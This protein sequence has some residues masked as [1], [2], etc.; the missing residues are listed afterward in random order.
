[1]F[2]YLAQKTSTNNVCG[3]EQNASRN[4]CPARLTGY[5][6]ARAGGEM[7]IFGAIN[8]YDG[9]MPNMNKPS[10]QTAVHAGAANKERITGSVERVTFHSEESGFAVLKVKVRGH[11]ELV[12]VVGTLPNI[13]AGEWLEAEGV[14]HIDPKHGQQFKA[15]QMRTTHPDTLEGIEKYLGSGMIKG[16]GPVYAEKLVKAFGREVFEVIDNRSALLERVDGIGPGRRAAIKAAWSEHKVVREIMTFLLSHGVSTARAFRIYKTYGEKAIEQ[17]LADPY[18]LA[19]DIRGIG[20]KTADQIALRMGIAHNSDLRARAG[21]EFVL[22]ELTQ[23]GH[24]AYPREG[25]VEETVK[26][27]DIPAVIVEAAIAYGIEQERLVPDRDPHGESVIYLRALYLAETGFARDMRAMATGAH[28]CPAIDVE[29][30]LAWVQ[31]KVNLELAPSQQEAIRKA[32]RSKVMIITGGPGVGKTTIVNAILNIFRA[33]KLRVTLCAPT[34]RAA[35]RM[36]ETTGMPAKTIHRL[37]EFD[38]ATGQFKHNAEKKLSGDV[39]VVDEASMI[40]VVLA[41]QLMRAIPERAAVVWVGDIDQLPSVGPGTVLRDLI[42]AG[43]FSVCRLTE[44]FRQAAQ[45]AII[46]NAHRINHGQ[47]PVTPEKG[48]NGEKVSSDFYFLHQED[49]DEAAA[50]LVRTVKE[51]LPKR[52][53]LDPIEHVQVITPMQRGVLGARALNQALQQALNPHGDAIERFGYL[54]RVGDKVM[55]MVNDYQ[56]DVFNGDSGRI[57]AIDPEE[58]TLRVR[59]EHRSVDYDFQE[60]DELAL[61]Y[62]ITVHK[63][64]GSEYPFVVIPVHTQH[65]MLLQRNLLYTAITRGKKLVLLLGS[66]KA[67]AIAVRNAE[68]R[69][70]ITL[71]RERLA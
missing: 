11:R 13:S 15:V 2:R 68:S 42:E 45:S 53:G 69:R 43:R 22:Q 40:D 24:C 52:F 39:F 9:A 26:I 31:Q 55:Q 65:Y 7:L 14:W 70:R 66:Q 36:S 56:K 30:A 6:A 29:R 19:R 59:F 23:E 50:R 61:S 57:T 41:Y 3:L 12:A 71:L 34:G 49:A 63:S 16:I 64:Q 58:R 54:F 37:L 1:M 10:I 35:K 27:L 4:Q 8:A 5:G 60:L 33:K 20:F 17:V 25:L 47:L 51:S 44:V 67:V 48:A 18:C 38:P 62:A 46:T 21:V 32:V 28:P